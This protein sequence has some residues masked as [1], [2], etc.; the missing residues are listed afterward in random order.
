MSMVY[1]AAFHR[2]RPSR[3]DRTEHALVLGFRDAIERDERLIDAVDLDLGK[4]VP[5]D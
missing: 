5:Q 2:R 4:E 1:E 3:R